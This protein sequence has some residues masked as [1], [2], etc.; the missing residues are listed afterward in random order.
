MARPT[1]SPSDK[2]SAVVRVMLTP[3]QKAIIDLATNTIDGDF[4]TWARPILLQ[5]ADRMIQASKKKPRKQIE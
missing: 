2:K 5:E 4:S 1:K 3:D